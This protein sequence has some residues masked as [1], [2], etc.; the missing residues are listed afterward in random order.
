MF[1]PSQVL[2]THRHE[3]HAGGNVALARHAIATGQRLRIVGSAYEDCPGATEV[4][5][6]GSEF[7]LF[8]S[9]AVTVTVDHTP[10]H[11]VGHV[12]FTVTSATTE[13]AALFCG[14]TL[15]VGGCGRFF[16]G[17]AGDMLNSLSKFERLDGSTVLYCGH[18]YTISNL[19]F[20]LTVQPN[21]EILQEKLIWAQAQRQQG[22]P[23]VPSTL[24]EERAYNP[25]LRTHDVNVQAAVGKCT[26]P[27]GTMR[28]LRE[29][30]DRF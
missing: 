11:T 16:E 18:E 8:N 14:D 19:Q 9:Q 23:T 13:A 7:K 3:D 22:L 20:A 6:Q 27:V 15:F 21:N 25:F 1:C 2:T 4:V 24:L 12:A 10:C 26:D 29:R 28:E 5:E 30:K 17:D